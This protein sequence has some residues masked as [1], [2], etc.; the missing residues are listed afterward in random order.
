[1]GPG[2]Y[3]AIA[4]FLRQNDDGKPHAA[5]ADMPDEQDLL[6]RAQTFALASVKFYER[7]PKTPNAQVP[8]V[9]YLKA[10]T[11]VAMNYRAARRGRSRAEFIAKLGT[12]VEEIDESVGWLEI[13][14]DSKIATDAALFSE[15]EQ[16]RKIFGKALGTARRNRRVGG[17]A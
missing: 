15:A 1:M 13:L 9:Q 3:I 12:V 16:L 8:G 4:G 10:S 14:R 11:A 17:N 2:T 5:I 7:L 6:K